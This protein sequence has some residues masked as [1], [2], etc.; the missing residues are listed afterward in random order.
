MLARPSPPKAISGIAII[1]A[2]VR[3]PTEGERP[4]TGSDEGNPLRNEV[5]NSVSVLSNP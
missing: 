2:G 1:S 5:C 3:S 4:T